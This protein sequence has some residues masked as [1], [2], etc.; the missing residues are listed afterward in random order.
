MTTVGEGVAGLMLGSGGVLAT[1]S[2]TSDQ[3]ETVQL[4]VGAVLAV[5]GATVGFM[6]WHAKSNEQ[7]T[8][9][10]IKEHERL[11]FARDQLR[12]EEVMGTLRALI[13]RLVDR[14]VLPESTP[15]GS[16]PLLTPVP[17][18]GSRDDDTGER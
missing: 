6:V 9:K 8:K 3:I 12:H 17:A 10:A 14:G 5:I 13:Q 1:A 11:E 18:R 16:W 4:L 15:S 2:I 7:A